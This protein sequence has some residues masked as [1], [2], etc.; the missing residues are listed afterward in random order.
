MSFFEKNL[1][2]ALKLF[3]ALSQQLK[4]LPEPPP[5]EKTA[6]G[7]AT[8]KIDGVQLSGKVDPIDEGEKFAKYLSVKKAEN[9][10]IYGLGLGYHLEAVIRMYPRLKR[11]VVIEPNRQI[12]SAA[13]HYRDLSPILFDSR[14]SLVTGETDE[15]ISAMLSSKLREGGEDWEIGI[16]HPSYRRMPEGFEKLKSIFEMLLSERRFSVTFARQEEK[17]IR[18]NIEVIASSP[19]VSSLFGKLK[20]QPAILVGAG[21]SLDKNLPL[22]YRLQGSVFILAVDTALQ[23]LRKNGIS[24]DAVISVDPQPLSIIHFR[25]SSGLAP[26]VF[27]P[28]THPVVVNMYKGSRYIMIKESHSFFGKAQHLLQNRGTID[29][30]GSVSS[31]AL[32]LLVKTGAD[33]IGFAGQDF[34]FPKGIPYNRETLERVIG[35][36]GLIRNG[37]IGVRALVTEHENLQTRFYGE[38]N[39]TTHSH[40]LSYHRDFEK[41][42][43]RNPDKHF[44]NLNSSGAEIKGCRNIVSLGEME[45]LFK[46]SKQKKKTLPPPQPEKPDNE[47]ADNLRKILFPWL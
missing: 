35:N 46:I 47:L 39:G 12:L 5:V 45:Q 27:L 29:A 1:R 40:L 43:S 24:F 44:Y 15:E 38:K 25:E 16:H 7:L 22:L 42:I 36:S 19:G 17:N 33:P 28:T 9:I 11:I 26:L 3:P 23:P 31:F 4:S 6:E 10:L 34:A 18:L 20:D 41:I 13:F 32:G 37:E 2:L 21:P 14:L 30:G 8:V